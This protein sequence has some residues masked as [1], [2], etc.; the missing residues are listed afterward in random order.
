MWAASLI[1]VLFCS[2]LPVGDTFRTPLSWHR[3]G[4]KAAS[5]ATVTLFASSSSFVA[6]VP[7]PDEALAAF[8]EESQEGTM[9]AASFE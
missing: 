3:K 1:A 5:K 7:A 4:C 9:W 8:D 6:V 2:L